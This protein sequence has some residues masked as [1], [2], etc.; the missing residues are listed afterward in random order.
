MKPPR[1]VT[2]L[3]R[4]LLG[5][6]LLSVS[7]LSVSLLVGCG[8]AVPEGGMILQPNQVQQWRQ[9]KTQLKTCRQRTLSQ[10]QSLAAQAAELQQFRERLQRL[11]ARLGVR[12]FRPRHLKTA[13]S[14]WKLNDTKLKSLARHGAKAGRGKL[15]RVLSGAKASVVSYWA[16]WCKPCTS[17]EE[18]H[19]LRGL[20]AQIKPFGGQVVSFAVDG[21]DAVQADSRAPTWLYPVVQRDKG[22]LETLPEQ[23]VRG[24]SLGLPMF[25]VVDAK[26]RVLFVRKGRLDEAVVEELVTAVARVAGG[27][28]QAE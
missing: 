7:L 24:G 10:K 11:E 16:T 18:L 28:S 23:M 9:T 22:H 14:G 13:A 17:K 25:T 8:A 4:R 21:L 6:G 2:L 15:S 3:S 27:H 12:A 1:Y 26:G 19:L 5:V 20:R